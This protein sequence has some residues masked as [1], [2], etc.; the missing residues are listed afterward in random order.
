MS[1][2]PRK[3]AV[4]HGER[5]A[6]ACRHLAAGR[7]NEAASLVETMLA[8]RPEDP[9]VLNLHGSLL[10]AREDLARAAEVYGAAATAY[11]DHAALCANLGLTHH[12]AGRHEE[13][14][15]CLQRAAALAPGDDIPLLALATARLMAGDVAEAAEV[16]AAIL[17]RSPESL[18]ALEL[19]GLIALT[20]GDRAEAER[21]L[22]EALRRG[23]TNPSILRG[24][25]VCCLWR[26]AADEALDFAQRGQLLAPLDIDTLEHLAICQ[27]EAGHL[28]EAEATCAKVL[29]FA[30][31]HVGL[32]AIQARLRILRGEPEA[33]LA[34]LTQFAKANPHST[35]A[36][37]SLAATARQGGRLAEAEALCKAVLQREPGNGPARRLADDI[38]LALG[39]FP[40]R[41]D[42]DLPS[43]ARILVPSDMLAGEFILLSRFLPAL[44]GATGRVKLSA[45]AKFLSLASHV[46]VGIEVG[47]PEEGETILPL[48]SALRCFDVEADWL[49][50]PRA[51]L[52]A[53]PAR[54]ALW[55]HALREHPRPWIG[56][57]W[58]IDAT[59][60]AMDHVRA[61][62][63]PGATAI[64]LMTGDGRHA[65][66][67]W[68]EAID[69]GVRF[70][71]FADMI[72]AV[73]QLD[74]VIGPDTAATHLA[75]ALGRPGAA[76]VGA[77]QP[78]CWA[79]REDRALWYPSLRVVRQTRPGDWSGVAEA[80]RA[81]CA[82]SL[83]G[84]EASPGS[85]AEAGLP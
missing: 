39:R 58:T 16:A 68:P 36:L 17:A 78:W 46:P 3:E 76:A 41:L 64:S 56:V 43:C 32:R 81:A 73:S 74:A 59:G 2:A 80:L 13:A 83:D 47:P 70:G 25:S 84:A 49:G 82:A 12:L 9:D 15:H 77:H 27:A 66:A 20:R 72:A 24:L 37:A 69:A 34:D 45:E 42:D 8:L 67:G 50:T 79:S 5:L 29:A 4:L 30:P 1:D 22:R 62:I 18:E 55:H 14:R 19:L 26:G 75:G 57:T 52:G 54:T 33:A 71:G 11:P 65:L 44:A 60:L 61:A 6:A 40:P 48:R 85:L 23:S 28:A 38:A 31:K 7:L 35:E 21:L 53:D 63:P 10:L 51:Y